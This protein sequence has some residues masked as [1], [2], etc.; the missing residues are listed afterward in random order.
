M[1]INREQ[2]GGGR[3]GGEKKKMFSLSFL[4]DVREAEAHLRERLL[5]FSLLGTPTGRLLLLLV[6]LVLVG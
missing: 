4:F 6:L 3:E 5:P 2:R 1:P